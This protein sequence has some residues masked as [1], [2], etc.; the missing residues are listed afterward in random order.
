MILSLGAMAE[1]KT[2]RADAGNLSLTS[3]RRVS[4]RRQE[5]KRAPHDNRDEI[6]KIVVANWQLMICAEGA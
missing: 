3:R 2:G 5:L 6:G 1:V 4:D